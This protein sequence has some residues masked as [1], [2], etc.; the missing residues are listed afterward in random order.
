MII[1]VA[2]KNLFPTG[3]TWQLTLRT[4]Q[5][6]Q[7]PKHLTSRNENKKKNQS[8]TVPLYSRFHYNRNQRRNKLKPSKALRPDGVSLIMLKQLVEAGTTY[9]TPLLNLSISIFTVLKEISEDQPN[10]KTRQ[11]SRSQFVVETHFPPITVVKLMEMLIL[12][13]ITNATSRKKYQDSFPAGYST[14]TAVYQIADQ[15]CSGLNETILAYCISCPG[16]VEII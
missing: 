16:P 15:I 8:A 12:P 5:K 14:T 4:A 2:R 3:K 6:V 9:F 11:T 7:H 10:V 13:H 1:N